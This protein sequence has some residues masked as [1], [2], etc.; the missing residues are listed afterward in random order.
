[1]KKMISLLLSASLCLSMGS[2]A[3]AA[4]GDFTDV[5]ETDYYSSAVQWAVDNDVTTGVSDDRFGATDVVTRADLYGE[6]FYA[7]KGDT[8]IICFDRFMGP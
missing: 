3:L 7:E 1:M 4:E 6:D 2:V 5:K 8:A